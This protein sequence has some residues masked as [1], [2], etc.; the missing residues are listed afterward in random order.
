MALIIEQD[1]QLIDIDFEME[2]ARQIAIAGDA[3]TIGH[4][5]MAAPAVALIFKNEEPTW[6]ETGVQFVGSILDKVDGTLKRKAVKLGVGILFPDQV[7]EVKENGLT[8]EMWATLN[9]Y[10]IVDRPV[11]DATIDKI[12]YHSVLS[13]LI[14]RAKKNGHTHTVKALEANL[15][16]SVERDID[17]HLTRQDAKENGLKTNA[18][19]INQW[20]T[21]VHS[22]GMGVLM[23]P[24]AKSPVGRAIGVG[25]VSAGTGLGKIGLSK[26]KKQ[27][28]EGK[29]VNARRKAMRVVS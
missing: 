14:I 12:Y 4:L 20:K 1:P 25:I 22:S 5:I 9:E 19:R 6:V 13:A 15:L 29:D 17:M 10:G 21:V 2:R 3:A 11:L 26:Y 23:S 24:V 8:K 7:D 28:R 27:V 18:I 16:T